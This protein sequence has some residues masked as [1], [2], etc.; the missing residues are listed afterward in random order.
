MVRIGT[1]PANTP[2][3]GR[4]DRES[5]HALA[6]DLLTLSERTS[7]TP[8]HLPKLLSD[9]LDAEKGALYRPVHTDGTWSLEFAHYHGEPDS[10][11]VDVAFVNFFTT[12]TRPDWTNWNPSQPQ[13]EQRNRVLR[14]CA[15][16][17]LPEREWTP[18]VRMIYPVAK[19]IDHETLRVVLCNGDELLC[20]VGLFRKEPFTARE[21]ELFAGI[22]SPLKQRWQWERRLA[23]GCWA[24]QGIEAVLDATCAPA[25]L[26]D[27]AGRPVFVNR[28][29]REWLQN[30]GRDL[31][32]KL[33]SAVRDSSQSSGELEVLLISSN[34]VPPLYLV[35][36]SAMQHAFDA[37]FDRTCRDWRL[38][39][40]QTA[41]LRRVLD[42]DSNKTIAVA[43][44]CSTKGI[45]THITAIMAKA[46]V[47]S[48]MELAARFW[49]VPRRS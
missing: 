16:V 26:A 17:D 3:L 18:V 38:S 49:Q 25:L 37:R 1:C 44:R 41:V 32:V 8:A 40:A 2:H 7:Y 39:P 21:T 48:R 30:G 23:I 28:V 19:L 6:A 43:L 4:R 13:P 35:T 33:R 24:Q 22:L 14:S 46:R 45:E 20:W 9:Y 27:A 12:Q 36:H 47:G 15:P 42:G 10:E 31:R 34:G 5:M 11:R 29:G